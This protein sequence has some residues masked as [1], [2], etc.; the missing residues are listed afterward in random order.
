MKNLQ[1][2][3][4][5]CTT[6]TAQ[7]DVSELKRLQNRV[8]E[9]EHGTQKKQL[10]IDELKTKLIQALEDNRTKRR[11]TVIHNTNHMT[12]NVTY[13]FGEEPHLSAQNVHSLIRSC[14]NMKDIVPAYLKQKHFRSSETS[15]IR[16]NFGADSIETVRKDAKTGQLKWKRER[17]NATQFCKDLAM[18]T[19]TELNDKYN[20]NRD[21]PWMA[22]CNNRF[23]KNPD[24]ELK[25]QD[26]ENQLGMG[27]KKMILENS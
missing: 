21:A 20:A 27:V 12:I 1:R 3:I 15:N 24:P 18:S 23:G 16:L 22:F 14:F 9:L 17:K 5:T 2:H 26:P 19:V 11:R 10:E 4:A 6:Y 13:A 8:A 25:K 7:C